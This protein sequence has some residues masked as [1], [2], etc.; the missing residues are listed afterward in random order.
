MTTTLRAGR[1]RTVTLRVPTEFRI[2]TLVMGQPGAPVTRPVR[3]HYRP[4]FWPASS[5]IEGR[6]ERGGLAVSF[7]SSTAVSATEYGGL[8]VVVAR[9]APQ[10]LSWGILPFRGMPAR[11]NER[12]E[13]TLVTT[14]WFTGVDERATAFRHARLIGDRSAEEARRA[15]EID[16]DDVILQTARAAANGGGVV[17]RLREVEPVGGPVT[18]RPPWEFEAA[19]RCDALERTIEPLAVRNG[20]VTVE[21]TEPL[22]TVLL[23]P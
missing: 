14:W 4:T 10:E 15:F 7:G 23:M 17:L 22:L 13:V 2:D 21:M 16:R 18:I 11:G 20:I 6:S 19:F 12:D 5:W 1:R 8:D 9:N 3:R